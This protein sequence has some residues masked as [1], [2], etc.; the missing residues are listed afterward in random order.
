[1]EYGWLYASLAAAST[2]LY[3]AWSYVRTLGRQITSRFIITARCTE[4]TAAAVQ[5]FLTKECKPSRFG[6]RT[7]AGGRTFLPRTKRVEV[8]PY[9]IIDDTPRLFWYGRCP[10]FVKMDQRQ[11]VQ[12]GD[13]KDSSTWLTGL[14]VTS[15]RG[16]VSLEQLTILAVRQFNAQYVSTADRRF[17]IVRLDNSPMSTPGSKGT[18]SD[19]SQLRD[20]RALMGCRLL[21]HSQEDLK[22][23]EVVS[24]GDTFDGLIPTAEMLVLR[25]RYEWWLANQLWYEERRLAWRDGWLLYGPPGTG[26][27]SLIRSIAKFY[28]IPLYTLDLSRANNHSLTELFLSAAQQAPAIVLLEDIDAV[29]EGRQPK[30]RSVPGQPQVYIEGITFERM[31]ECLDGVQQNHGV[32]VAMTTNHLEKL[33]SAL[34]RPGRMNL[35]FEIGCFDEQQQRELAR[36]LLGDA[37]EQI[38]Y[39]DSCAPADLTARCVELAIELK[40]KEFST[41]VSGRKET[42]ALQ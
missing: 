17:E 30:S 34:I 40:N 5:S 38:E 14:T 36:F 21:M 20:R 16:F 9:E 13:K 33:D 37:A 8:V 32:I 15:I 27:T 2:M 42:Q 23:P 31:L 26:K 19:S 35:K 18:D 12:M 29:F 41:H 3:A 39:S 6:P 28:D 11:Q 25:Q 10:L 7:Y 1:M 24:P 22:Y 4:E